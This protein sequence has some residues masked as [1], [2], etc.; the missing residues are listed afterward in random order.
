[1]TDKVYMSE[2]LAEIL[3]PS[4]LGKDL[5]ANDEPLE[6]VTGLLAQLLFGDTASETYYN[7]ES[8]LEDPLPGRPGMSRHLH[9]M[10][11]TID[12]KQIGKSR[13]SGFILF[14]DGVEIIR[15]APPKEPMVM[16]RVAPFHGE[17][18]WSVKLSFASNS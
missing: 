17:R 11:K 7:V 18:T 6:N 1:M 8:Y 13:P 10:M 16:M 12:L 15:F 3:D 9:L 5:V 14:A 2:G 4:L